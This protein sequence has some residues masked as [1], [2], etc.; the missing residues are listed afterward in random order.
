MSEAIT[1]AIVGAVIM[2]LMVF[3]PLQK[4]EEERDNYRKLYC[5]REVMHDN[6]DIV[7]NGALGEDG[8]LHVQIPYEVQ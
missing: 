7:C 8:H 6:F 5:S 1:G 3:G 2:A 4:T